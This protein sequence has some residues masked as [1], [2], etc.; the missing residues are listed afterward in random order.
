[1]LPHSP[2]VTPAAG[3]PP[4]TLAA[5]VYRVSRGVDTSTALDHARAELASYPGHE[6]TSAALDAAIALASRTARPGRPPGPEDLE[7]LGQGW[8]GPEALALAVFAV[9]AAE[10][11]GGPAHMIVRTGLLLSVNHSG[12]S[13]ATG[14]IA[15]SLL[16]ARYGRTALPHRW[17]RTVDARPVLD[18]LA[19]DYCTEFGLTPPQDNHGQPTDDWYDRYPA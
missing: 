2:T 11:V 9:L 5:L 15:G 3:S 14:S 16:G 4:G 6:E 12:D 13:D 8:I 17:S 10:A 18:R 1:M 19:T 7:T